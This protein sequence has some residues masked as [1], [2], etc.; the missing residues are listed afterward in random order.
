[1]IQDGRIAAIRDTTAPSEFSAAELIDGRGMLA[2][3][4]LIN[5]HAHAPMVNF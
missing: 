1:M 4:G 2:M 3:P 5:T